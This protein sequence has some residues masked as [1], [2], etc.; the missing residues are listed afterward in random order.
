MA[1]SSLE[2]VGLEKSYRKKKVVDDISIHVKK[3]EIVGLL[4]PNGAGKTTTFSLILGLIPQDAGHVYLDGEDIQIFLCI[5]E[6]EKDYACFLRNR[7][8]SGN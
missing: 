3:G 8:L 6:P 4:G 2:A 1:G 5:L 7:P